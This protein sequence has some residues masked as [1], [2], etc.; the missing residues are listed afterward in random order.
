MFYLLSHGSTLSAHLHCIQL[1]RDKRQGTKDIT[2]RSGP[3]DR[4]FGML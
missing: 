2:R 1:G 3:V 4:V